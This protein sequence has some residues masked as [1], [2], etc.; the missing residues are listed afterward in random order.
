M[1]ELPPISIV[2]PT[3]NSSKVI[4]RCLDEIEKQDYPKNKIEV[5][6]IDGGS[7]DNTLEI[8]KKY[9]IVRK[10]LKNPL[11][12]G[13]AGKSV[14]VGAAK[15][16]FIALVDSDNLLEG[17]DWIKK[18]I[19]P[20]KDKN[21][22][23]TEP[24]FF[25]YRKNDHYITRYCAL[26]GINDPLCIFLGNY[27]RWNYITN[28]WTEVPVKQKDKNDYIEVTLSDKQLPTIGANG[29]VWRANLLKKTKHKPYLFDIDIPSQLVKLG[30]N[31]FAKVKTG[32]IHLYGGKVK[33]FAKKQLRRIIE[34]NKEDFRR[35]RVY[36][37]SSLS[38]LK[39]L[40][41]IL[42]TVLFI[43][44]L[45]QALKGYS[46]KPDKA[47]FFHIPACWITLII[48]LFGTLK[49]RVIK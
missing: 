1:K 47:W 29:T 10:I 22:S 48:Y 37:W 33:H 9:K 4:A 6:I 2:I 21:I 16:E 3:Y 32:I 20:F 19:A 28:T 45:Y 31:K 38:K 41:F 34:F 35:Y 27:D 24:L 5:I 23:G 17:K 49:M 39:L 40:K 11:R 14:G 15:G 7:K 30:Y 8:V 43:P 26:T 36:P 13:E 46:H 18:M 42:Y 12:T 25:T 44:L